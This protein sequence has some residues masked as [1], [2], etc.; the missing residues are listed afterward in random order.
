MVNTVLL[1]DAELRNVNAEGCKIVFDILSFATNV[2]VAATRLFAH[3][4]IVVVDVEQFEAGIIHD[5]GQFGLCSRLDV[6]DTFQLGHT[7]ILVVPSTP[8]EQFLAVG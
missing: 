5:G 8:V 6:I 7:L 4:G 1:Q 3:D 2:D